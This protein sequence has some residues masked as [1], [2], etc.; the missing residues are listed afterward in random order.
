MNESIDPLTNESFIK[1]R[2]NM[3]FATREHRIMFHAKKK[4]IAKELRSFIDKP[5]H[6]NHKLLMDLIEPSETKCFSKEFLSAMGYNFS[7]LTHYEIYDG[8]LS[9]ALYNFL[10][11]T[12]GK[13]ESS[14]MIHRKL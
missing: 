13:N 3:R 11:L 2:K 7:V 5:L 12:F 1:L 6:V 4:L 14:T 10:L 8:N 9:A